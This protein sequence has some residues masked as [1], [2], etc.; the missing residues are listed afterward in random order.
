MEIGFNGDPI[1]IPQTRNVEIKELKNLQ[2]RGKHN[3]APPPELVGKVNTELKR[4]GTEGM[5]DTINEVFEEVLRKKSNAKA[6]NLGM[7][8][9]ANGE[10]P[11]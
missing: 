9:H 1:R 4:F 8:Y 2:F 6:I 7:M 10:L 5:F 11:F 3:S